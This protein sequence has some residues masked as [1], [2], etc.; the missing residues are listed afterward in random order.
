MTQKD[1]ILIAL[2]RDTPVPRTPRE[3]SIE[4]GVP[5]PSVRRILSELHRGA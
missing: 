1:L 4:T 2:T 5:A 3:L